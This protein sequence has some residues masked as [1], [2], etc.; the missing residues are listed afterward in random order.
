[1]QGVQASCSF[2]CKNCNKNPST[3]LGII[4]CRGDDEFERNFEG[5][6]SLLQ[7]LGPVSAI[8]VSLRTI[9]SRV[10]VIK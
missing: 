9:H 3:D 2:V 5:A 4:I 1:M 6:H 10:K 8:V 7:V